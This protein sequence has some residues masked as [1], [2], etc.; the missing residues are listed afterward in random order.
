MNKKSRLENVSSN[1]IWQ[2]YSLVIT[3]VFPFIVR[4]VMLRYFGN[5]YTGVGS[6]FISV[7]QVINMADL[8]IDSAAA[9]YLYDPIA[10]NDK[11]RV[12]AILNLLK[13]VYFGIGCVILA[14]GIILLPFLP[15]LVKGK[16]YPEGLNIYAIYLLYILNSVLNYFFGNYWKSVL[17][18]DQRGDK[19]GQIGGTSALIM[20]C[21]QLFAIVV[22]RNYYIY[23][24][25]LMVVTVLNLFFIRLYAFRH[26][27]DIKTVGEVDGDFLREFCGKLFALSLSKLRNVS[28][29]S[30]DSIVISSFLGLS[31]LTKYQNYYQIF[32]VPYVL[33]GI[34][35]TAVTPSLGNKMIFDSAT[36]N[37]N[38]IKKISHFMNIVLTVIISCMLNLYQ[39][40]IKIWVG[41]SN[42]LS[43]SVV[44]LFC[45]YI[46]L[47]GISSITMMIRDSAGIWWEG[48]SGYV[49]EAGA[50]LFLNYVFGYI[51]GIN[52]V[53]L[54][55]VV[56]ILFINI[57]WEQHFVFKCYFKSSQRNYVFYCIE[58]SIVTI[59]ISLLSFKLA[60]LISADNWSGAL[61]KLII[62]VIVPCVLWGM[63]SFKQLKN[64]VG[65]HFKI[66]KL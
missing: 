48:K 13:K 40:M 34:V 21:L 52:G 18:A 45:V 10:R 17:V 44:I 37:Y 3:S 1:F 61:Y 24:I 8:G 43:Y 56:T 2:I 36:S 39:V 33:V 20:Y 15:Y 27:K 49:I 58:L 38:V 4:T 41:E 66:K 35:T 60:S 65:N 42:L 31:I 62:S 47:I 32:L 64:F 63:I 12:C 53:I 6:L 46:Y 55:T 51:W 25:L 57:P 29:N 5:E 26:Y 59:F 7:L 28:R 50:N 22:L 30:F 19:V 9:Y 54:A 14:A 23:T 11:K 16:V